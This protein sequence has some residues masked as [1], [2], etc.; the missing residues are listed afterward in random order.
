MKR[1]WQLKIP[2]LLLSIAGIMFGLG[3]FTF[4]YA[5]GLSYASNKP[6]TCINCHIMNDEYDSWEKSGH[7]HVAVCVDCHLPHALI[8]K[9][10]AKARNG[11]NH[12]RA[13]TLG[14][15]PQPIMITPVNA[16]ILQENCVR[17]HSNL[18]QSAILVPSGGSTEAQLCVHCHRNVGHA[19]TH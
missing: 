6:E 7:H 16:A 17:C 2:V 12:S 1:L 3:G 9:L 19:P 4:L 10:I 13:F 11:Y 8:P 5:G 18:V 14:D 15:Y